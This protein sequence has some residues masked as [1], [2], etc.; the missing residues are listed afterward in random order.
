MQ[1]HL[2]EFTRAII[3]FAVRF[4]VVVMLFSGG[5][6]MVETLGEVSWLIDVTMQTDMGDTSFFSLCYFTFVTISTVGY[7]DYSP[8][9][10]FGRLFVIIVILGGVCFFSLETGNL[11]SIVK[12][13]EQGRGR[14]TP[15]YPH[16]KHV[17][18]IGGGV[19]NGPLSVIE[20]FL[21]SLV[22][23][24]HG[25]EVPEV[26]IMASKTPEEELVNLLSQRWATRA[27]IKYLY[28][29]PTDAKDLMRARITN[30]ELCYVLGDVNA[31]PQQ[32][33][34]QNIVRAAAVYRLYQTQMLVMMLEAKN[35]R[36][37]VQAGIPERMCA[38]LDDLEFA[39]LAS[40]CQCVGLSTLLINLALPD[41]GSH[42]ADDLDPREMWM[43][44]YI[45]GANKELYGLQLNRSYNGWTFTKAAFNIYTDSGVMLIAAQDE[46]GSVV[47]N[48]GSKFTIQDNSVFFCIANDEDSLDAIRRE[49]GREWL[50]AYDQ[51]RTEVAARKDQERKKK[52]ASMDRPAL[53]ALQELKGVGGGEGNDL[54]EDDAKKK[55][56]QNMKKT[57]AGKAT[58]PTVGKGVTPIGPGV[59][60]KLGLVK[61]VRAQPDAKQ[62]K[63]EE[64]KKEEEE[65]PDD[66]FEHGEKVTNEDELLDIVEE[67]GHIV[68][69]GM[70]RE[71]GALLPQLT[72][73]IR[74]LRTP[75]LPEALLQVPIV[76]LYD[77]QIREKVQKFFAGFKRLV[78]VQG[79]PLRLRSLLKVGAD[80]CSKM[81]IVSGGNGS[82]S[83]PIMTDQDAILLLAML[84][85][86]EALWGRLPTVICQ[87]HVPSN[88]KQLS[89][90]T[91]TDQAQAV[92]RERY[93]HKTTTPRKGKSPRKPSAGSDGAYVSDEVAAERAPLQ[94]EEL[95][96]KPTLS[97][98]NIRT[99]LRCV[100]KPRN[101]IVN[102]CVCGGLLC[103]CVCRCL[104]VSVC[105]SLSVCLC[106]CVSFRSLRMQICSKVH[107]PLRL[108]L[109]KHIH[110][111]I[112]IHSLTHTHTHTHRERER[113]RERDGCHC[114]HFWLNT[115]TCARAH[116][117]TQPAGMHRAA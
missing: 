33:D 67:G 82:H 18:I 38:G 5:M 84:E 108:P 79:S 105:V 54:E 31:S 110:I 48:P 21:K 40:S 36:F 15:R 88:I 45:K 59:I 96:S 26:V 93:A 13:A 9:T 24:S 51:N 74:Q 75:F 46:S 52:A 112:H 107:Y 70:G 106:L 72:T 115:R 19:T 29:N 28:G 76:L 117:H 61:G 86:Q 103:L 95:E 3:R 47:M 116:T 63:R 41:L 11:M 100:L 90:S 20:S 87:L 2:E 68:V 73:I 99:H 49:E 39:S 62:K 98:T 65:E 25:D 81:L 23:Q 57:P 8:T 80:R 91:A 35:I 17:L 114:E 64:K 34:L 12:L 104:C 37:A 4:I 77:Y 16:K 85:S 111:H 10:V 69:V 44:E 66:L 89:E 42:D 97:S 102:P 55:R 1:N 7:G 101:L 27:N 58:S 83:E 94:S 14:F 78:Y 6:Y 43:N 30:V 113:E 56:T 109:S 53:L 50:R 32:E 22:D 60:G 92:E 71:E